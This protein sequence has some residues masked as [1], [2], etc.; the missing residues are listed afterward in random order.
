VVSA[1]AGLRADGERRDPARERAPR[2]PG[3]RAVAQEPP[4][5]NL[6]RALKH[7][8]T[9]PWLVRRT[10]P[11]R[12]L[13][14]IEVAISESE[15]KHRGEIRFAVD[16][17]LDFL[18]VLR[19]LTP[20]DRALEVFSSLRVWDT[21]ENTGVLIYLQLVDHDIEIVADRGVSARIGSVQWEAICHRMEEAFRG[22]RFEGGVL[23]GIA[24]VTE[25]LALH[26]PAGDKNPDELPNRPVSL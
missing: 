14:R 13:T 23:A 25:L 3:G 19:G 10:F 24:E 11:A 15:K 17:P 16:G 2:G 18:A 4:A 9:P 1:A 22:G 12:T 8:F 5:V 7:L 6:R 26:F 21:A 20:R